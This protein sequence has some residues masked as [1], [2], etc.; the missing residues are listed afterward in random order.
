MNCWKNAEQSQNVSKAYVLDASAILAVLN[1]ERGG[2][3][4]E[5]MLSKAA[6]S[7]V[8][9]AEVYT[10]LI[11]SGMEESEARE[12][13]ALLGLQIEKFDEEMAMLSALLRP[14]TK[15][16]GLSLGDRSCLALAIKTKATAI[17]ADKSW[18]KVGLCPIKIIR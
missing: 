4:V 17:T 3:E 1:D 10:K 14:K 11:E 15:R 6:V 2:E 16:F 12:S 18:A 13:F 9:V 8:N 7:A 5:S